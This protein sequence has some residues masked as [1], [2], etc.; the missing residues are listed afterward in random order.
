MGMEPGRGLPVG[1][2]SSESDATASR[3]GGLLSELLTREDFNNSAT[4][5]STNVFIMLH[6]Q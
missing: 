2:K 3:V 5:T 6:L 4:E 1:S